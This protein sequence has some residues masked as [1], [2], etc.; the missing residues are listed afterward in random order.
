MGLVAFGLANIMMAFLRTRKVFL[1]V[2]LLVCVAAGTVLT[3]TAPARAQDGDA[4]AEPEEYANLSLE[5]LPATVHGDN[6]R[7]DMT[8]I[9]TNHGY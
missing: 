3:H 2:L 6:S 4:T 5:V 1:A 8:I 7:N 9:V